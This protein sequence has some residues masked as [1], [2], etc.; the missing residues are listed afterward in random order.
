M[1][2]IEHLVLTRLDGTMC[3]YDHCEIEVTGRIQAGEIVQ[4]VI[5]GGGPIRAEITQVREQPVIGGP[6]LYIGP[7]RTVYARELP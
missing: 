1:T 3:A 2:T 7:A 4:L 5:D 6:P